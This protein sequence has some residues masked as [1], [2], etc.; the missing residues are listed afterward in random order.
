MRE[1]PQAPSTCQRGRGQKDI[2]LSSLEGYPKRLTAEIRKW[3]AAR[4]NGSIRK[5]ATDLFSPKAAGKMCLFISLLSKKPAW[6]ASMR[7]K[8]SNTRKSPTRVK[9]RP[10]ISRSNANLA[11]LRREAPD[12]PEYLSM[13]IPVHG[14]A[15]AGR[16]GI[17]V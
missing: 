6:A 8:W 4:L 12:K 7:A 15:A 17:A 13:R 9:R 14:D 5:K 3:R 11:E 1:P 16:G 10:K 2:V